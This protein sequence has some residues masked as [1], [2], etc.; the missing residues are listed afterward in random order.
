MSFPSELADAVPLFAFFRLARVEAEALVWHHGG[1]GVAIARSREAQNPGTPRVQRIHESPG[2]LLA[3]RGLTSCKAST[4]QPTT[5]R[6]DH[7]SWRKA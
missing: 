2:R 1:K 4:S 3:E 5:P 6:S 7:R